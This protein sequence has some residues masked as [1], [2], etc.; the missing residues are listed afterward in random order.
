[1]FKYAGYNRLISYNPC[2]GMELPK[3]KTKDIRVLTVE[4]QKEVV[5]HVKGRMYENVIHVGLGTRMR[6][7]K[8]LGLTWDDADFAK[9]KIHINKTAV[10]H[11]FILML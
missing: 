2:A 5:K 3:T 9:R 10:C 11:I 8:I 4:E 1:M 7:G 6:I